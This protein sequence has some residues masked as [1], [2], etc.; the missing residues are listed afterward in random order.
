MKTKLVAAIIKK[1]R[2]ACA[3]NGT[4]HASLE[5]AFKSIS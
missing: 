5:K 1:T 2:M 4:V 3:T